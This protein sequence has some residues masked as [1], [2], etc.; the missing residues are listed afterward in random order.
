M[1]L[2]EGQVAE[3]RQKLVAK[4]K[5]EAQ[6]EHMVTLAQREAV[7]KALKKELTVAKGALTK[8]KAKAK[9]LKI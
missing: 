4:G 5:S 1:Q 9:E 3:L 7:I 8:S 6:A 2:Y